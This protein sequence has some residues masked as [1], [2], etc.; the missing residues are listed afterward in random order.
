VRY[1]HL[2]L[3]TEQISQDEYMFDFIHS[4]QEEGYQL[5]RAVIAI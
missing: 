1:I 5:N 2:V 4:E 3:N